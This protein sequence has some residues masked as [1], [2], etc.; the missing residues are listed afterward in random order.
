MAAVTTLDQAIDDILT[1]LQT[2]LAGEL[3]ETR[4]LADVETIVIGERSRPRPDLPA[5][6]VFGDIAVANHITAG[7][8]E[9]WE[10]PVT[11]VSI[12]QSDEPES[13]YR[14][15]ASIAARARSVVLKDRR[16]GLDF[17]NDVVSTRFEP[18]RET[19]IDN[20]TIYSAAA[21]VTVRFRIH[22]GT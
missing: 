22:E 21:T 1:A 5:L 11:L 6:W 7:I 12:V 9:T 2:A 13:A 8:A 15:A 10:L 17:V 4:R 16:L 18:S 14:Q 3:G 20:R 19:S